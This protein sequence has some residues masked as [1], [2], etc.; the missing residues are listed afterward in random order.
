MATNSGRIFAPKSYPVRKPSDT[1]RMHG[2][3]INPPRF[4][5]IGGMTKNNADKREPELSIQKPR[6]TK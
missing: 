1:G 4:P 3:M 5:E 2:S 6:D